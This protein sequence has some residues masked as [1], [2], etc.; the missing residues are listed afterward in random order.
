MPRDLPAPRWEVYRIGERLV[1]TDYGRTLERIA[2]NGPDEF[3]EGETAHIMADDF[4]R[5]GGLITL[6]DLSAYRAEALEPLQA[7]FRDLDLLTEPAPTVGP[8]TVEILNIIEGWDLERAWLELTA[9][10]STGCS[11]P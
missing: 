6:A 11:G 1:Q 10:I 5:N 7:T 4:Q 3:Y 2:S 8:V 9:P